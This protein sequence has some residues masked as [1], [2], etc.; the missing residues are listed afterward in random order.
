MYLK[1]LGARQNYTEAIRWYRKAAEQGVVK[2][3]YNV[4]V[5]YEMGRG[6][7]KDHAQAVMWYRKAAGQGHARALERLR[8]LGL[9]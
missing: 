5:A 1:G 3:Q 8:K 7:A 4:G 6:V 2:A 9:R